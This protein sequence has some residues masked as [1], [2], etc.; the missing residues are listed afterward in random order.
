MQSLEIPLS[1]LVGVEVKD[2]T[3][4]NDGVFKLPHKSGDDKF[5]PA[6]VVCFA[7]VEIGDVATCVDDDWAGSVMTF[8]VKPP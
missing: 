3:A 7:F 8:V 4:K 5:R 2:F 1:A 6:F